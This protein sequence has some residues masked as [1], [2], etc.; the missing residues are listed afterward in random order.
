MQRL[1]KSSF[2]Q[3]ALGA[4]QGV[5]F[6]PLALLLVAF[7]ICFNYTLLRNVKEALVVTVNEG[8][9][10]LPFIKVWA[11]LPI[12]CLLMTL[13]AFVAT[14]YRRDSIFQGIVG[15]FLLFFLFFLYVIYPAR[16]VLYPTA[17]V[18]WMQRMLPVGGAGA[19][20]MVAHWPLT[21]FYVVAELWGVLVLSV[22]FWGLASLLVPLSEA[23]WLYP[24]LN[25]SGHCGCML[26]GQVPLM[27]RT[28]SDDEALSI[29]IGCVLLSGLVTMWLMHHLYKTAPLTPKPQALLSMRES[30]LYVSR[31]SP[32]KAIATM[33]AG[34]SLLICTTEV[35]WKNSL[36]Q[37]YPDFR[38]Y[39]A[40]VG[41]INSYVSLISIPVA[42][43]LPFLLRT[44]GWKKIALLPP[45][46]LA[47]SSAVF[48][49]TF[50]Y[51]SSMT[52]MDVVAGRTAFDILIGCG[53]IHMMLALSCKYVLFDPTKEMAFIPLDADYK[54]TSKAA[55]DGVGSRFAHSSGSLIMQ[56]AMMFFGSLAACAPYLFPFL[57]VILAFWVQAVCRL[58]EQFPVLK[59]AGTEAEAE[60]EVGGEVGVGVRAGDLQQQET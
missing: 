53:S 22:L 19:I 38:D 13:F 49:L 14:R 8:A 51:T 43:G 34:Y 60:V 10:V 31:S 11:M 23:R 56:G 39:S 1:Y 46:L 54:W 26:A 7:C 52:A 57:F 44:F 41:S 50:L 32:L 30:L 15:G 58:S 12:T 2:F 36:Q 55:I 20:G 40:Y 45:I 5:S 6:L 37:L 9:A 21:L 33:V 59:A 28:A 47:V 24:L 42:L 18:E 35:F 16:A 3:R 17:L 48:C 27:L 25:V 29:S 4:S